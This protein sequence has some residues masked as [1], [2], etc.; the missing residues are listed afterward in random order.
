[1]SKAPRPSIS[2][3]CSSICSTRLQ[4]S[5][6]CHMHSFPASLLKPKCCCASALSGIGRYGVLSENFAQPS[7]RE[8]RHYLA[9]YNN[10]WVWPEPD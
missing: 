2:T 5:G 10:G 7:L 6:R 9:H 1:M 3:S 4:A 8:F